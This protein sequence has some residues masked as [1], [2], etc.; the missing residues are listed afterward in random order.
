MSRFN[1]QI[2][3]AISTSSGRLTLRNFIFV[4]SQQIAIHIVFEPFTGFATRLVVE[5]GFP[6]RPSTVSA[7]EYHITTCELSLSRGEKEVKA[8]FYIV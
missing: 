1:E 3:S 7:S 2:Q 8:T 4:T 6:E 5:T